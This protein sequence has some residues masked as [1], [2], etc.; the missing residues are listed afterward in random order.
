MNPTINQIVAALQELE[1]E[2]K[3][4]TRQ[5]IMDLL[6]NM[7]ETLRAIKNS[8]AFLELTEHEDFSTYTD[9]SIGDAIQA[10][11]EIHHGAD[12]VNA[13][14][15]AEYLTYEFNDGQEY[16]QFGEARPPENTV[17]AEFL[18]GYD[19]ARLESLN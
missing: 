15:E 7:S 12:N 14:I 2:D 19:S 4:L 17:S 10:L 3:P 5:E 1:I 11:D 18:R 9:L 16:Y 13:V 6:S 8:P